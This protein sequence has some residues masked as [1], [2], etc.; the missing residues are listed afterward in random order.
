MRVEQLLS[1]I[2]PV[3]ATWLERNRLLL[4]APTL[5]GEDLLRYLVQMNIWP[6]SLRRREEELEEV[7]LRLTDQEAGL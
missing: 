6:E 7:F 2:P 3:R 5:R 4:D 1:Q